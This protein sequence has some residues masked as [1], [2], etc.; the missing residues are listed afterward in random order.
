[1]D[2]VARRKG[3]D[4]EYEYRNR[5]RIRQRMTQEA[6]ERAEREARWARHEARMARNSW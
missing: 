4:D 6:A 2:E 1:M 3:Q 5:D